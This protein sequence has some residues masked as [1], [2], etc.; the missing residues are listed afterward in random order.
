M[1][2]KILMSLIVVLFIVSPVAAYTPRPTE[3]ETGVC[4]EAGVCVPVCVRLWNT[5]H[6]NF[7]AAWQW[8]KPDQAAQFVLTH[9]GKNVASF[10]WEDTP[11][12]SVCAY[13]M[14]APVVLR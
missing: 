4:S 7:T 14:F 13:T 11:F 5:S 9:N 2:K 6:R 3:P 10:V 1:F 8:M 12:H